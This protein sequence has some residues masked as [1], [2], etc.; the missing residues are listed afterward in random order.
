MSIIISTPEAS[1][2]GPRS[3]GLLCISL[4]LPLLL[5][6][7]HIRSSAGSSIGIN[8]ATQSD[9]NKTSTIDDTAVTEA[10]TGNPINVTPDHSASHG[11]QPPRRQQNPDQ[12]S[13][14][15]I[16]LGIAD[17]TGPSADINL[18]S[19]I[20]QL[21][22]AGLGPTFEVTSSRQIS[23]GLGVGGSNAGSSQLSGLPIRLQYPS[24]RELRDI[25]LQFKINISPLI[26]RQP[27][28][29]TLLR[30]AMPNQAKMQLEY[31]YANLVVQL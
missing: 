15:L 30:W 20:G 11:Q 31:T 8:P 16:G 6:S 17:I 1:S 22:A 23:D 9:N 2:K 18:V 29:D 27:L 19:L 10:P 13:E 5:L 21:V 7:S 4:I 14:Y 28:M 26:L 24:L 12:D 25:K 3:C